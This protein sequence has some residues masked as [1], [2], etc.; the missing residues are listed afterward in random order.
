MRRP[1][2]LIPNRQC[3]SNDGSASAYLFSITHASLI[4]ARD[5][6]A[7]CSDAAQYL[8][9]IKQFSQ[10]FDLSKIDF[11][12]QGQ[13]NMT[14]R[15]TPVIELEGTCAAGLS[16]ITLEFFGTD[17]GELQDVPPA[18]RD[19]YACVA[20]SE[21]AEEYLYPANVLHTGLLGASHQSAGGISFSPRRH[22]FRRGRKFS[23]LQP[24]GDIG[25]DVLASAAYFATLNLYGLDTSV[26]AEQVT[27]KTAAWVDVSWCAE[28]GVDADRR[29]RK[30]SVISRT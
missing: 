3:S 29:G 20:D 1:Q 19:V 8:E 24:E 10:K 15:T 21:T 11:Y 23:V 18:G 6:A 27:A 28:H 17:A 14:Q 4:R 26:T 2:H 16:N 22:A 13:R 5:S 9:K 30:E 7:V 25:R 12:K